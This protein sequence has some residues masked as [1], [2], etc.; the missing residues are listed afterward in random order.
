MPKDYA[1]KSPRHVPVTRE[2][3]TSP[4]ASTES[5]EKLFGTAKAPTRLD[6]VQRRR[7]R[8]VWWFVGGTALLAIAAV[9]GFFVF[10]GKQFSGDN[11]NLTVTTNTEAASGDVITLTVDYANNE[12]VS[13]G[14]ASLVLQF[15]DGFTV[16]ETSA[17]PQNS[18]GNS[19]DLATLSSGESGTLTITGQ[20]DGEV[21]T[22][23]VFSGKLVYKPSDFNA[24]FETDSSITVTITESII[25]LK[26][27]GPTRVAP[28]TTTSFT[29]KYTSTSEGVLEN[30]TIQPEWPSS[31][32]PDTIEPS[33][34]ENNVWSIPRLTKSEG[35][36]VTFS[37]KFT[38]EVGDSV[39][40]SFIV[41]RTTTDGFSEKQLEYK[42]L[43][44]LVSGQLSLT[45]SINGSDENK[46]VEHGTTMT[47]ELAY[48]N[49]TEF[50][51]TDVSFSLSFDEAILSYDEL[52]TEPGSH[53]DG[54]AITWNKDTYASLASLKPDAEGTLKLTVPIRKNLTIDTDKDV[55]FSIIAT[56]TGS[57]GGVTDGNG[58]TITVPPI[59]K[60]TKVSS[61]LSV[62]AEARYYADD[63]TTLGS[64]PLPPK[65]GTATS[66]RVFVTLQ[67]NTNDV[68]TVTVTTKLPDNVEWKASSTVSAGTITYND[69]TRTV[70]WSI[71]Q[72]PSG[73]G[74]YTPTLTAQFTLAIT[75]TSGDVGS[76]PS[77]TGEFTAKG[78]D[79]YTE[80]TRTAT[81]PK[82]STAL[83]EDSTASGK[84]TV[85]N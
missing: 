27:D 56:A 83:T 34:N 74:Y 35:G 13:L 15:P 32:M 45:M 8:P 57:V 30:L 80:A 28:D 24:T 23:K 81:A 1:K 78:T 22:Q 55:N 38:G 6:R 67:N 36:S 77:L 43:I 33:L 49:N 75:P 51:L 71:N 60:E 26:L 21:G 65:A 79:A 68:N 39:Q 53:R 47:Y 7:I 61:L 18:A 17:D 16:R 42:P 59:T 29:L 19:W 31:F 44:L 20:L 73:S 3:G 64:G 4:S 63:G 72:I 85:V 2:S 52:T 37:G 46:P 50:E 10:G 25:I 9:V 82:L 84:G 76:S 5:L 54:T 58:L 14:N 66:Y 41:S 48:K 12:P 11:V 40:L 62:S 70:T 69:S